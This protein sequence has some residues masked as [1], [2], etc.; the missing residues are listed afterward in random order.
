M[1]AASGRL[2]HHSPTRCSSL[3]GRECHLELQGWAGSS[4]CSS[5]VQVSTDGLGPAP[6]FTNG[7]LRGWATPERKASNPGLRGPSQSHHLSPKP[8]LPLARRDISR[9]QGGGEGT[10]AHAST[11]ELWEVGQ[12][13]EMLLPLW[14]MSHRSSHGLIFAGVLSNAF[15]DE[16]VDRRAERR[17]HVPGR[18]LGSRVH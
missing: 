11:L 1:A 8:T 15:R 10:G 2:C 5:A 9:T 16:N 4:A 7:P 17:N 13:Q 18:K 6:P 3:L 12:T 14:Q